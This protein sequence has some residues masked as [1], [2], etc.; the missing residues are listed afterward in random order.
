MELLRIV[1][2]LA[3]VVVLAWLTYVLGNEIQY[4]VMPKR[5]F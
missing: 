4:T 3:T 5:W 1:L 2:L